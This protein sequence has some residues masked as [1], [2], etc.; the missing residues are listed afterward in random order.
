MVV[1]EQDLIQQ[2]QQ[3]LGKEI[4]KTD[5][6]E[7]LQQIEIVEPQPGQL[8]WHSTDT[9]VGIFVILAGKIRVLDSAAN[10]VF[11]LFSNSTLGESSIFA[12][13]NWQPCSARA[14]LNVRLAYL[15]E[16]L[17]KTI[18]T[19]YPALKERWYQK[20]L[21]QDLLLV[22]QSTENQDFAID[23]YLHQI[24]PQLQWHRLQAGQFN[25]A[26]V[27]NSQLWLLRSGAIKHSSGQKLVPGKIYFVQDLPSD[28]TWQIS[29]TTDLFTGSTNISSF[30]AAELNLQLNS[31]QGLN[32][33]EKLPKD[34]PLSTTIKRLSINSP[35]VTANPSSPKQ[36]DQFSHLYFPSPK[37]KLLHW[38]QK[39]TQR[40]P[41]IK[42]QS[43]SDCGVACLTMIGRYWGKNFSIN[44]LRVLANV[45]RSGA[46][47]KGLISAAESLGFKT[48]PIKA[49]LLG[50]SQL[51]LPAIAHWEGNHYIVVYQISK[52]YAI[53]ADPALGQR[54][55]TYQ[56]FL[57]GWTGYTLLLEPTSL[58]ETAPEAK[59]DLW[60]FVELIKPHW[61]ILLEVF[62]AS[63]M[64]QIF[65]LFTPIFTQLLL[66]RVVVQR[67]T[68][69]LIAIGIGLLLFSCFRVVMSSLRRY[70]LYHTANKIDLA[71]IVG[72]ISYTF[73]LPLN[74]FETRYVGDITSRIEENRK[75]RRFLTSDAITT[76]LDLITVFVYL[77]LMFWYS[78]QMS[79]LTLIIIP[80]YVLVA[81]I[82]TPFLRKISREI[83]TA[84]TKESSYLIEALNGINTIKSMGLE[85]TV[86]WRWEELFNQSINLNFSGQLIRERL[87]LSTSTI[88]MLVNRTLL[89]FGVW[90][91][92][93]NRLTIGQLIAFNMLVGNVISPFERLIDLWNDF[94]EVIIAVERLNDV[95]NTPPEED[96]T[97]LARSP[98]PP[99][100]GQIKFEN[101]T[102]RYNSESDKNTL[103]NIS[104]EIQPGQTVALVGRSGSGKTTLA[105]LLLSLYQPTEGK[106]LIDGCDL[107]TI[108][109]RTLRQQVGVVDQNT[110]LFGGTIRDNLT[111][112]HPE[113]TTAEIQLAAKLA[114]A[115]EF[116]R[117]LPLQYE[118]P[119]GESGGLLSG[120][121]RQRLA[122]ARAL[123]G[124]PHL[125]ILDEAT[126]NLDAESERIIQINFNT[127]LKHQTTLIIAHRLSTVRNADLILVLDR[128]IL[129]E[130][131]THE[132]LMKQKGQYYYLNQQQLA[133]AV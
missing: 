122:I 43:A 61:V 130:S 50:L 89:I 57:A 47:I 46:S 118:T 110:F 116:I 104:F 11:S 123:L 67:S 4:A 85:R 106:I 64:I 90:L 107:A 26:L 111:V 83:F 93:Q 30:N 98:L 23:Q 5:L 88:E 66:D 15:N 53:V 132:E 86:G 80:V 100:R 2:L 33:L 82:A 127:I 75:V 115:E 68:S 128:G 42:Q 108:S 112:A 48:R 87:R 52:K 65:G 95:I 9:S 36:V 34:E 21:R 126:S 133:I 69:T 19:K 129:I 72:F 27:N 58:L 56:E 29:Q 10:Q 40:Y 14:S 22:Y 3:S 113:A 121:Q 20:A 124:K 49:D 8:F 70:L 35:A 37:I 76:V 12:Q 79:L 114:G 24:L 59:Q 73:R 105:K 7:Y 62:I 54:S 44:H 99:I 78:W 31:L 39:T 102:F 55:L 51:Q 94:Q 96:L 28:G 97:A 18:L 77:G 17:I 63:M 109:L 120:G 84:K 71:L 117:Q 41:F 74:Y 6:I 60:K 32:V 91:V 81:V 16:Q 92:I 103:E 1:S 25:P 13:E 125:L 45:D 131:G 38:W 119:I 101:V